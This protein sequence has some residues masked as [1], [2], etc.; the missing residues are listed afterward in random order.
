MQNA[1]LALLGS[2]GSPYTRKML[3][4]LRYRRIPYRFLARPDVPQDYPVPRVEL[5]PTFYFA[6]E[7]GGLV[8][9]TDSTPIIRRLEADFAARSVI[10]SAPAL[11]LIDALIEDYADEWL[12][13]AMFHYR[14]SY[15]DD[16]QK[17]QDILPNWMMGPLTDA[18]LA[19]RGRAFG[20]RQIS[21]LRYVGSNDVTRATIEESYARL[22]GIL[23][24]HF[25]EHRFLLGRRPGA[26]DFGLF[27]QLTQLALFDPTPMALTIA[28]APRVAAWTAYIDDLSGLE[29]SEDDW[30]AP[31]ALPATIGELLGEIGRVYAPLLIANSAAIEAGAVE[32]DTEIGGRPWKQEPFSYQAK[33]LRSLRSSYTDLPAAA[34]QTVDTALAGTGCEQLFETR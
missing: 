28:R 18:E 2:P 25:S 1:S 9:M 13:K 32:V 17:S 22:I 3:A 26:S 6:G 12:T 20:E 24:R 15:A 21:R 14:W 10:P 8:A 5:L 4:V 33:C 23:S 27:G 29:P 7:A 34:R 19:E 11:A 30:Y 31:A 16:I